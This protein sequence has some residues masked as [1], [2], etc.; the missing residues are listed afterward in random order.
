[1]KEIKVT[2]REMIRDTLRYIKVISYNEEAIE[3]E[4]LDCLKILNQ[5]VDSS[6]NELTMFSYRQEID[7]DL[8]GREVYQLTDRPAQGIETVLYKQSLYAGY[9][10]IEQ[11]SRE[12][13]LKRQGNINNNYS[14]DI[15]YVYYNGTFPVSELYVYPH[16]SVGTLKII[17]SGMFEMF[18]N[19]DSIIYLPSGFNR[20]LQ[21]TL[22][23]MCCEMFER[24][25]SQIMMAKAVSDKSLIKDSNKKQINNTVRCDFDTWGLY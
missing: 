2:A 15:N 18:D 14:N 20:Y 19:L 9:C 8:D 12:D 23:V 7:I 16:T 22:A 21:S 11:V 6:N 1:M 5:I 17:I 25:P 13:Y 4:Y 3:E 10:E 24:E